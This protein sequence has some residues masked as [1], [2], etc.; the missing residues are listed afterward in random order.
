MDAE[1]LEGGEL[2]EALLAVGVQEALVFDVGEVVQV[3]EGG[4]VE[5]GFVGGGGGGGEGFLEGEGGGGGFGGNDVVRAEDVVPG[6][7]GQ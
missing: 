4:G 7:G 6:E 3:G 5:A 2:G 1:G